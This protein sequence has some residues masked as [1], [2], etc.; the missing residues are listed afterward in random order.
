M[1]SESSI[2]VVCTICG[3]IATNG[4]ADVIETEPENGYRTFE[5]ILTGVYGCDKHPVVS[6]AFNRDGSIC[7]SLPLGWDIFT[8]ETGS[9]L[10]TR[11]N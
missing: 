7:L 5:P 8:H 9:T 1:E 4:G 3:E 6:R 2:N 11:A 10:A